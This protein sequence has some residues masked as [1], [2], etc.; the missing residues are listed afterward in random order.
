MKKFFVIAA[1]VCLT[2]TSCGDKN[3]LPNDTSAIAQYI[4]QTSETAQAEVTT[5]S[6]TTVTTVE[7]TT[8]TTTETTTVTTEE[9][10]AAIERS[11]EKEEPV[12]T[13]EAKEVYDILMSDTDIIFA[14][15]VDGISLIDL[16]FDC[17]PE[18]LVSKYWRDDGMDLYHNNDVDIY[19]IDVGNGCLNYIDTIYTRK[20][21]NVLGL[22]IT[23]KLEEKWFL[24]SRKTIGSEECYDSSDY[25]VTLNG[26][27]LHYEEIFGYRFTGE[28]KPESDMA[29]I[30]P[31]F[32]D[33]KIDPENEKWSR[34]TAHNIS[35][36]GLTENMFNQYCSDIDTVYGL[37]SDW[38]ADGESME[39]LKID[40]D[41]ARIEIAEITANYFSNYSS[42]SEPIDYDYSLLSWSGLGR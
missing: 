7:T 29:L 2:F 10:T 35:R 6:E 27:K 16:D 25:L 33:E 8:V 42:G 40:A 37:C 41:T 39:P 38:L 22:K 21:E 20:G 36:W 9:I 5:T 31:Y 34:W 17:K 11:A 3:T 15:S 1:A 32:M 12:L 23:D 24:M 30:D 14:D 4:E 18:L 28:F 13:D 26:G 19:G